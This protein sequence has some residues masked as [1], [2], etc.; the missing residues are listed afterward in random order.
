MSKIKPLTILDLIRFKQASE[1]IS[2]LT[3]YDASFSAVM[4]NVGIDLILIG[5][6]L[7]MV[8]QGH[9]TT[10][11]VTLRDII[12]HSQCVTRVQKR[13]FIMAD[14]PFATYHSK[15]VAIENS[16]QLIQD[17]GAQMVK[18]E[19]VH[20]DIIQHLVQQGIPVCGHLG[21]LPQSIHKTGSYRTQG[22]LQ[23]EADKIFIDA[24]KI[25]QSG[26]SLLILECVPAIL[27]KKITLALKIPVIGIGA[28][29]DCDGQ[30]LVL[31]DM[32]GLGGDKP[33]R[34]VHDFMEGS[35]NIKNAIQDYHYAVK[36][37]QFPS[38]D[39]SY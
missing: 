32:L 30:I 35:D 34:F 9:N 5:D 18:L 12:Y 27:A 14:L 38:E 20:M 11:P 16:K 10:T 19:G 36:S 17:G 29:V 1:K 4:D 22:K 31:H 7:G 8:V 28:G 24:Q 2:C 23:R 39:H 21:V 25:E 13:A 33:P 37:T 26:A 6:S 15:T 3:A